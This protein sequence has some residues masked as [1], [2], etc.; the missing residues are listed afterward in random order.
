MGQQ[1]R[2]RELNSE[3]ASEEILEV[4]DENDRVIGR[5]RRGVIHEKE[6]MH[7]SAQILVFNSRGELFLQKR[8]HSKDEFPGLWDSSAAG[9]VNPGESYI[10]CARRE[11]EEELGI[12]RPGALEEVCRF[13]ASRDTGFEH[14]V[15]HRC[16]WDGPLT[17][18]P[19]EVDDGRWLKPQEMDALVADPKQPLTPA[20][21]QIWL[22]I[23]ELL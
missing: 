17:F 12:Y 20:I 1:S 9:H 22:A 15:V 13:P 16:T 8:S 3:I 14:C 23:R 11:L 6:L 5:E 4:V 19:G 7:R 2:V 18:Q 21:R 10:D